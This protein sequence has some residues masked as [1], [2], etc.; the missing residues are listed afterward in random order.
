[1]KIVAKASE[2]RTWWSFLKPKLFCLA[3][4]LSNFEMSR[5]IISLWSPHFDGQLFV[6]AQQSVILINRIACCVG[7]VFF[8]LRSYM[9]HNFLHFLSLLLIHFILLYSVRKFRI[10]LLK[11]SCF[12]FTRAVLA[13]LIKTEQTLCTRE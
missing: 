10:L 2:P 9:L 1:M 13:R 3:W 12:F 6:I 11:F 4:M 7:C 8:R 5:Y